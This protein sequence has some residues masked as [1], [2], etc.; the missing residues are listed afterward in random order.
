MD[1]Q[2]NDVVAKLEI[3][4]GHDVGTIA[5][6]NRAKILA[7]TDGWSDDALNKFVTDFANNLPSGGIKSAEFGQFRS[8]LIASEPSFDATVN[9]KLAD[10]FDAAVSTVEHIGQ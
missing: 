10:A 1:A 5:Q 4:L 8:T 2:Q 7:A 3:A 9:G 6:A